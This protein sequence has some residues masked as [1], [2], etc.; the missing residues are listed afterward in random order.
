MPCA[1]A[2]TVYEKYLGVCHT[3]FDY[4][5]GIKYCSQSFDY[6]CG[7]RWCKKWGVSYP[8]GVKTCTTSISYPC[9]FDYCS[10]SMPYPCVRTR[11]V[12]GWC[13]DFSSFRND[14]RVAYERH[15]GCCGGVEYEWT[16]KCL[17]WVKAYT[18]GTVCFKEKPKE[19]GPCTEGGSLPPGGQRPGGPLDKN[20]VAPRG[21]GLLRA[22][23]YVRSK[24][25][26][27]A[28]CIL[29]SFT[30][31]LGSWVAVVL[32]ATWSHSAS[33]VAI[34]PAIGFTLLSAAH[35]AAMARSNASSAPCS[36][37]QTRRT[38]DVV[39]VTLSQG[40]QS[41]GLRSA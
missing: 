15:K 18:R 1:Y 3:Q 21:S 19:V 22:S 29:L 37:A 6:P 32:L 33:V 30:G 10:G 12:D 36:C 13:Y 25:G 4:P 14:C 35:V 39:G 9:G 28:P 2:G 41:P 34:L 26:R 38:S 8:C 20:S 24:L 31:T 5:C 23:T 11:A 16:S 17:G 27:C 40:V 7:I